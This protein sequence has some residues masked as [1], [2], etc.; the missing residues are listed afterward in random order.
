MKWEE[1]DKNIICKLENDLHFEKSM[2]KDL[3]SDA[4][5]QE[6]RDIQKAYSDVRLCEFGE[7]GRMIL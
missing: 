3:A 1:M 4:I 6:L 7:Q 5:A 2:I